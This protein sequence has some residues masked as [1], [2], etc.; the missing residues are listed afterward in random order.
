MIRL[1]VEAVFEVDIDAIN[2]SLQSKIEP[3]SEGLDA[4]CLLSRIF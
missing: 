1:R 3:L 2:A 4:S